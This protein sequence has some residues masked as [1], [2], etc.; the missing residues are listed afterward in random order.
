MTDQADFSADF[1]AQFS[2]ALAA[3]TVAA[4][5][6]VVAISIGHGRHITGLPW[7]SDIVVTSEQSLPRRDDFELIASGG[8]TLSAKLAGRDSST[9]IAILR[10]ASP[11]AAPSIAAGVAQGRALAR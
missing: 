4:S 3:R 7:Q 11:L 8:A 10:P 9:N 6:A 2:N 5:S 1:L